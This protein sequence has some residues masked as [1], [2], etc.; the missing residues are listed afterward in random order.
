VNTF[1]GSNNLTASTNAGGM[2][3]VLLELWTKCL[4]IVSDFSTHAA[5]TGTAVHGLGTAAVANLA[6]MLI[7]GTSTFNGASIGDTA[8]PTVDAK[9]VR[10]EFH[11]YGTV[12]ANAT[13]TIEWDKYAHAAFT[14]SATNTDLHTIAFSG[15]PASGV[16]QSIILEII[17]GQRLTDGRLTYPAN[18]KWVGGSTA[19][20][21]DT[22]LQSAGRDFFVVTTRD[23]GT[24]LEWQY[25]GRGG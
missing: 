9:R 20:P 15:L 14:A 18:S 17:N 3:N 19:R 5:A 11:D 1:D 6:S 21:L 13:V 25:L 2:R 12:L 10:E 16:T 8:H 22:A 4:K 24:R 23:N 7:T